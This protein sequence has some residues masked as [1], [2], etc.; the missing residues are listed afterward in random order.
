[1]EVDVRRRNRCGM[2]RGKNTDTCFWKRDESVTTHLIPPSAHATTLTPF[3]L[4][5]LSKLPAHMGAIRLRSDFKKPFPLHKDFTIKLQRK[6]AVG[7]YEFFNHIVPACTANH[8]LPEE[9]NRKTGVTSVVTHGT[10]WVL[11]RVALFLCNV[12]VVHN[13]LYKEKHLLY[14]RHHV[15]CRLAR[16]QVNKVAGWYAPRQDEV[17]TS[18]GSVILWLIRESVWNKFGTYLSMSQIITKYVTKCPPA[19]VQLNLSEF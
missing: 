8:T 1:M 17:F 10:V 12:Q 3:V 6:H 16:G 4:H 11:K 15:M 19:N 18:C 5:T 14:V 9:K 7:Q 2:Y 13:T